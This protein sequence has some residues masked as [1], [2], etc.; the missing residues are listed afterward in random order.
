MHTNKLCYYYVC[1]QRPLVYRFSVQCNT[2]P[3]C[4]DYYSNLRAAG[5]LSVLRSSSRGTGNCV[6]AKSQ[7]TGSLWLLKLCAS[8]SR[9]SVFT[10]ERGVLQEQWSGLLLPKCF[11][12]GLEK[13]RGLRVL[14]TRTG[15]YAGWA[16]FL[17]ESTYSSIDC[18][19]HPGCEA[20]SCVSVMVGKG[21]TD[22][23]SLL[24]FMLERQQKFEWAYF[25][26][27]WII[28][29]LIVMIKQKHCKDFVELFLCHIS[30]LI[31]TLDDPNES[32]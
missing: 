1:I 9:L 19:E 5:A 22:N 8:S 20:S 31:G 17:M 10:R 6:C 2:V 23:S 4:V 11:S 12:R 30:E 26:I 7:S 25:W 21:A 18:V 16:S 29:S 13:R 15:P 24:C 32:K 27:F 3:L 28:F 14:T